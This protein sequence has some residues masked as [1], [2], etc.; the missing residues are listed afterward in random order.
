M[1][2]VSYCHGFIEK[3]NNG[4]FYHEIRIALEK[5][6]YFSFPTLEQASSYIH[7]AALVPF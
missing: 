7:L 1:Y 6:D 4:N 5:V 3:W 2:S